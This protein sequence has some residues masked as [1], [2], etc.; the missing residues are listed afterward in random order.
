[1]SLVQLFVPA[2]VAHN[3]VAKLGEL[4]N[5]EFKDICSLNMSSFSLTQTLDSAAQSR[6]EP[7]LTFLCQQDPLHRRDGMTH[8]LLYCTD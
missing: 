5:V 7:L 2:E 1:M 6:S 3:T 8:A 4:G